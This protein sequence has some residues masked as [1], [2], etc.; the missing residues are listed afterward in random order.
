V[1]SVSCCVE[2]RVEALVSIADETYLEESTNLYANLATN[3]RQIFDIKIN[4]APLDVEGKYRA[5]IGINLVE[6]ALPSDEIAY[7][8]SIEEIGDLSY[9]HALHQV[10]GSVWNLPAGQDVSLGAQISSLIYTANNSIAFDLSTFTA[11]I[12]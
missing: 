5:D 12:K 1:T 3:E 7:S 6:T 2:L 8:W 9:M 11:K 4:Q 10:D